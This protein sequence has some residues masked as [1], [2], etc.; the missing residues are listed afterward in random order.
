VQAVLDPYNPS[1]STRHVRFNTS[2]RTRWQTDP[3]R[4]HVNWVVCDS[5][6]EAEL[7]R[8]LETHKRVRRYV[9]NHSLGLEVPY[10]TGGEARRYLPDFVVVVD[11]GHGEDDL[12]HF[13]VE[14][15]GYRGEDAKDKKATMETYWVP[16]VNNLKTYGRW[17][18]VELRDVFEIESELSK[19]IDEAVRR[20]T[21]ERFDK[22]V[23]EVRG[24]LAV[25]RKLT[26]DEMNER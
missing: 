5:D 10:V 16:A 2:K 12:L 24:K 20:R 13:V 14:I 15:K 7:C 9:K 23:D 1:G 26:R 19:I 21:M 11:D 8:A 4:C 18:F 17:A 22:A 3:T 25:G 6:W